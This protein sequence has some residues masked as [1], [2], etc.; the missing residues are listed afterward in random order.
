MASPTRT[1]PTH[2]HRTRG[3]LGAKAQPR[4]FCA[5]AFRG[6]IEER[7]R[8]VRR[9]RPAN[10]VGVAHCA[11]DRAPTSPAVVWLIDHRAAGALSAEPR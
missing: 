2:L 10:A 9:H 8:R 7:D 6:V 4:T 5:E 3:G 11:P 1:K